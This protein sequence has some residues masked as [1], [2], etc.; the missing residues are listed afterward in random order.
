M[1]EGLKPGMDDLQKELVSL[2]ERDGQDAEE[3]DAMVDKLG[4]MITPMKEHYKAR[5]QGNGEVRHCS[6]YSMEQATTC[7]CVI[8]RRS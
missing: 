3:A 1:K 7:V 2:L 4:T 8:C 6:S 5:I